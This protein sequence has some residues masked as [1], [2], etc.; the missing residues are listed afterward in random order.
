MILPDSRDA[1]DELAGV[2]SSLGATEE[3]ELEAVEDFSGSGF[4]GDEEVLAKRNGL[5]NSKGVVTGFAK[6][7][8]Q[9][10]EDRI[11]ERLLVLRER[12]KDCWLG[13]DLETKPPTR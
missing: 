8:K 5:A 13:C 6:R 1:R 3:G 4:T 9:D 2:L 7:G 12:S 11:C 10:A